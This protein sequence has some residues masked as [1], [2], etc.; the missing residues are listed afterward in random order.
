MSMVAEERPGSGLPEERECHGRGTPIAGDEFPR[1]SDG[2]TGLE[3]KHTTAW[4]RL[5]G[6]RYDRCRGLNDESC[7]LS[8]WDTH[9]LPTLR[10]LGKSAPTADPT[11]IPPTV[12]PT[13]YAA[14][15]LC[16]QSEVASRPPGAARIE[17]T[18]P[19]T[20]PAAPP[21]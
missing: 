14:W 20:R 19:N 11:R 18:N 12:P 21:T 10:Q 7:R 17:P 13:M 1:C 5:L 16:P 8:R 9:L 2:R 4:P 15:Q 6:L 3:E